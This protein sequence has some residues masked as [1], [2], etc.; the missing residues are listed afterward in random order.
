MT[1]M[2]LTEGSH[3]VSVRYRFFSF[4]FRCRGT[5]LSRWA[6]RDSHIRV[7]ETHMGPS[8]FI[9]PDQW[10]SFLVDVWCQ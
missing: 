7:G 9:G 4:C 6:H 3:W 10:V 5:R 1:V 2:V 8:A